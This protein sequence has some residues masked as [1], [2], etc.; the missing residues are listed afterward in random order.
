MNEIGKIFKLNEIK[1]FTFERFFLFS[2]RNS[3]RCWTGIG[4]QTQN[5]NQMVAAHSTG[6]A[7]AN[8][9]GPEHRGQ[10]GDGFYLV[11]M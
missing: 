4:I 2:L 10:F 9:G 8:N 5:K 11:R 7:A 3:I 1:M 6:E